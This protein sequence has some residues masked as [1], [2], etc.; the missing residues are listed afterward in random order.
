MASPSPQPHPA[1]RSAPKGTANLQLNEEGRATPLP[2]YEKTQSVPFSLTLQ[3]E[4]DNPGKYQLVVNIDSA[5][6][7]QPQ[8]DTLSPT[9]SK[10]LHA[11]SKDAPSI[12]SLGY[13][14]SPL[15]RTQNSSPP[16]SPQNEKQ[17]WSDLAAVHP[18]FLEKVV[19][20]WKVSFS[21]SDSTASTQSRK[22]SDI[23][24]RIKKSGKGFVVRLLKGT[25]DANEVAEV[26]LG[27]PSAEDPT[28]PQELD[29]GRMP[30]ELDSTQPICSLGGEGGPIEIGTSSE[31][32][33]QRVPIIPLAA[34]MPSIPEWLNGGVMEGRPRHSIAE[35]GFSDAETLIPDIRSIAGDQTDSETLS[36]STSTYPV[37]TNSVLSIVKT[38]TRGLSVVG[39]VKRVEKAR[40]V[41]PTGKEH[42]SELTRSGAHKSIKR[43]SPRNSSSGI[44]ITNESSLKDSQQLRHRTHLNSRSPTG[45]LYETTSDE[46]S[47]RLNA[48]RDGKMGKSKGYRR[49]SGEE[50]SQPT[51]TKTRLRLNTNIS[52]QNSANTS[53]ISR[54]KKSPRIP[55]APG[56]F[57]SPVHPREENQ[58]VPSPAWSEVDDSD[59]LREYLKKVFGFVPEQTN[60]DQE[61]ASMPIPTIEEPVDDSNVGDIPLP[62]DMEIRS[63]P[64]STGNP[65]L[66]FWGLAL[67]ALSEKV[68]EGLHFV[69][70]RYGSEPPVPQNHVRVRWTCTCGES[71]YDDFIEQ[72]PGAARLLEAYLN[73][74]RAHAPTSP[75]NGSRSSTATSMASVFSSASRASTLA[76]PAST[77][78]GSSSWGGKSSKYSP[79]QLL[80]RNP[81]SVQI[82]TFADEAWLLTAAN[83][84]R[85]TPKVVHI[86]V[87]TSKIR[88]DKDLAL[89]LREHYEKLNQRWLNW[90]RLRGLTTI[91]FV[92]FEVHRNRFADIRATPSMPPT[93]SSSSTMASA[94]ASPEKSSPS[95]HPYTFEPVDLMPPVGS[96]YLLH[97]FRHPTDY[98]GE[99]VTYLRAPKRRERLDVGMGWGINLVEGFLAQK[100]WALLVVCFG[101]GSAAFA[102]AWTIIDGDIQG[103]FGV[104]GWMVTLT[105]LVLG[106]IQ[107]WLE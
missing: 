56:T 16:M 88:S 31:P 37:R 13:D 73:R 17:E 3:E 66:T 30:V 8:G 57:S 29:S 38:P 54:R 77:Y 90:I 74:P 91:E 79:T 65:T 40:R 70:E 106:G 46:S 102:I 81:F 27:Q 69:R 25:A 82:G 87:N 86:D 96:T 55:N 41:R 103:A 42:R 49:M 89:A 9:S 6:Q 28:S 50:L 60:P 45:E 72:R 24:A 100:V 4:K 63:A 36:R 14:A 23:K 44:S 10:R 64:A 52:R 67:S 85:F 48:G 58:H 92:Q 12:P 107:A 75:T 95:Q 105:G 94:S 51:K 20:D 1:S 76:T 61:Q 21:R 84:G 97:L 59:E 78:G 32:G 68:F 80:S 5:H 34:R 101:M 2:Q 15:Y 18:D 7:K 39:P 26:H 83:E 33:I 35:E 19:P 43:K 98:D 93:S 22:L 71:L 62:H 47:D 99:L 104:A 53:P 11:S